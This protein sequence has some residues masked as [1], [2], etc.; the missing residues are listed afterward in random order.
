[1]NLLIVCAPVL[2]AF[3][4]WSG[5][6]LGELACEGRA[7]FADGPAPVA[8]ARGHFA[9]G[10]L[11]AGVLAN[12]LGADVA[13]LALLTL[14]ILVLAACSAADLRCGQIPDACSLGGLVLVV[15]LGAFAND[16]APALG[17]LVI[18][19]PFALAAAATRGRAIGWG[20]VKV[21]ALG[22]ALLGAGNATLAFALAAAAAYLV[23][24]RMRTRRRPIAFGP[25]LAAS[26][27]LVA[28]GG[29]V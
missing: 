10:G 18:G 27:L 23:A 8:Y 4:A 9:L 14:A 7:P 17:A 5:A 26:I 15:G 25:F 16:A 11:V 19:I 3:A 24:R 6:I 28:L 1:M 21:A 29:T 13:Q 2:G 22:G 20:D 12:A